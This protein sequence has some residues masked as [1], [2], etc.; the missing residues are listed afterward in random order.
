MNQQNP[1]DRKTYRKQK[2]AESKS[3]DKTRSDEEHKIAKKLKHQI[4]HRKQELDDEENWE[5]WKDFYR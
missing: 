2:I 4:K 3:L 5:Y 1:E